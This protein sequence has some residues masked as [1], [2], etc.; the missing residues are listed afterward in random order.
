MFVHAA[1]LER[2]KFEGEQREKMMIIDITGSEEI[3]V[4]QEARNEGE[5]QRKEAD[6]ATKRKRGLDALMNTQ[7]P[8]PRKKTK[9]E[10]K[11]E[12]HYEKKLEREAKAAA[13]T[14]A[15]EEKRAA[16]AAAKAAKEAAKEAAK[17]K[18]KPKR[19]SNRD[20]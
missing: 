11:A 5:K 10:K 7:V 3:E 17:P 12:V 18:G 2:T 6:E 15:A 16:K 9:K 13:K 14:A 20:S 1:V 19:K 8:K 4:I